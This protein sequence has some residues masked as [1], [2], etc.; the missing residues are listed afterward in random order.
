MEY[1]GG[2]TYN[3]NTNIQLVERSLKKLLLVLTR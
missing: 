1:A 3:L 2:L